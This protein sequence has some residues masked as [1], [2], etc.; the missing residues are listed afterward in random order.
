MHRYASFQIDCKVCGVW[1]G[2]G[3]SGFSPWKQDRRVMLCEVLTCA[4]PGAFRG[5]GS[6]RAVVDTIITVGFLGGFFIFIFFIIIYQPLLAV[7]GYLV[8]GPS[9]YDVVLTVFSLNSTIIPAP[10]FAAI[11]PNG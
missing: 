10:L 7:R 5:D 11:G 4:V 3:G 1:Y 2:W 6:N 9:G 8:V